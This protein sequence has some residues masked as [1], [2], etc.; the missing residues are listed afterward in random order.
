MV[1]TA[2]RYMSDRHN[3]TPESENIM[4]IFEHMTGWKDALNLADPTG[5]KVIG[6]AT[7]YTFDPEGKRHGCRAVHVT[8]PFFGNWDETNN[9]QQILERTICLLFPELYKRLRMVAVD[10]DCSSILEL[11]QRMVNDHAREEDMQQLRAEF[12][13]ANRSEWGKVPADA[14]Y[15]RSKHREIDDQQGTFDFNK[16]ET[17]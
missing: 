7:Y 9:V 4:A 1:D 14:P 5:Q 17:T 8:K 3:L 15:R 12:E 6:E 16:E 2:I 11:L 13:D 10:M